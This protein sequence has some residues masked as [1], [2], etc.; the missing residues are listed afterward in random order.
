MAD[1]ELEH[2]GVECAQR[3]GYGSEPGPVTLNDIDV[4]ELALEHWEDFL[5]FVQA[6]DPDIL[7]E[8]AEE[9]RWLWEA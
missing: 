4:E 1:R 7:T 5:A 8:F 6:G 3:T 2:P 9:H